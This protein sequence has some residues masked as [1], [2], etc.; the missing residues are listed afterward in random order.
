MFWSRGRALFDFVDAA[1]SD[2]LD[3]ERLVCKEAEYAG[4]HHCNELIKHF[5]I[6]LALI[7]LIARG[8]LVSWRNGNHKVVTQM[9]I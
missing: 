7:P 5:S 3:G 6:A 4:I 8:A 1:R 2:L 9:K